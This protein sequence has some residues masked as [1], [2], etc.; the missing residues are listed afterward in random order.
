MSA[1]IREE[2]YWRPVGMLM[3]YWSNRNHAHPDRNSRPVD[4]TT[5]GKRPF[6]KSVKDW[7]WE[8]GCWVV[9]RDGFPT[10]SSVCNS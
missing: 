9:G 4:E 6:C 7:R 3:G 5:C 1:L 2:T 8:P 10:G